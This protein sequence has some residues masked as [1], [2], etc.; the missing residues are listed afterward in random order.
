MR[1][2][3]EFRFLFFVFLFCFLLKNMT[4][5]FWLIKIVSDQRE[6]EFYIGYG[7]IYLVQTFI[8]RR[9]IVS[10]LKRSNRLSLIVVCIFIVAL[11]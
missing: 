7:R 4:N 9:R 11:D 5:V 6:I 2:I 1:L 3:F 8:S 10:S